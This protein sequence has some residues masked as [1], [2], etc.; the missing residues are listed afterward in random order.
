MSTISKQIKDVICDTL[1]VLG[2]ETAVD[3][4]TGSMVTDGGVGIAKDVFIGGNLNVAGTLT[5]S[6]S[7]SIPWTI[8]A[9]SA[10]TNITSILTNR[11]TRYIEVGNKVTVTF[12]LRIRI[13]TV[14]SGTTTCQLTGLPVSASSVAGA[15]FASSCKY[16]RV[17]DGSFPGVMTVEV[18]H[19][20]PT[21]L[22]LTGLWQTG[23][24]W[25]VTG[26]LEYSS[27]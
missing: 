11:D 3:I 22:T 18:A 26:Q 6:F 27:A 12:D 1:T 8:F 24:D 14:A 20:N 4:N 17:S 5:A 7:V 2:D 21:V 10:G 15:S 13:D 25:D 16:V 9:L 23:E 19:N